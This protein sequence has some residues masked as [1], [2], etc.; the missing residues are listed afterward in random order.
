MNPMFWTSK[1]RHNFQ[2]Q[3]LENLLKEKQIPDF[4]FEALEEEINDNLSTENEF[5]EFFGNESSN[6]DQ[7]QIDEPEYSKKKDQIFLGVLS[8]MDTNRINIPFFE[9]ES[10][11][12]KLKYK[13]PGGKRVLD[14]HEYTQAGSRQA[15]RRL[16][17]NLNRNFDNTVK[18]VVGRGSHS[19]DHLIINSSVE[20]V[21]KE[22]NIHSNF[23]FKTLHFLLNIKK[24]EAMKED[25]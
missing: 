2:E 19:N 12:E 10:K 20:S 16:I 3:Y 6:F 21:F 4:L 14:L 24:D 11:A 7:D 9:K 15:V 25:T 13:F 5:D 23:E 1:E 8:Q 18:I 17:L 22:L